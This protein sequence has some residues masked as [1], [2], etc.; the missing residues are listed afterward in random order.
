MSMRVFVLS[1]L[2]LVPAGTVEA[3]EAE[4][5]EARPDGLICLRASSVPLRQLLLQ[6]SREAPLDVIYVDPA[7]AEKAIT[8]SI[9]ERPLAEVLLEIA[10][11]AEA[12]YI[13]WGNRIYVGDPAAAQL[14]TDP[15][16]SGEMPT[17]DDPRWGKTQTEEK[18]EDIDWEAAE[19]EDPWDAEAQSAD[20]ERLLSAMQPQPRP[21]DGLLEL[22]F[23]DAD[24]SL[25]LDE[26]RRS[27]GLVAL[28]FPDR[29][30]SLRTIRVDPQAP[31][32]SP[33]EALPPAPPPPARAAQEPLAPV[34]K[35]DYKQ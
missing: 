9:E 12:N 1:L 33:L 14:L 4:V 31:R 19:D 23:P 16:R 22:P 21:A 17:A 20:Y 27:D 24:G 30:G 15:A 25:K 7:V 10:V 28:P 2:L 3:A 32:L 29:D 35:Q 34:D 13:V 18:I 11:A 5:V 8:I 26:A 6:V